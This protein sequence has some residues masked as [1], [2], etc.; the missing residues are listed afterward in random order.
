MTLPE[1]STDQLFLGQALISTSLNPS[2]SHCSSLWCRPPGT[3]RLQPKTEI[4]CC[5]LHRSLSRGEWRRLY[6]STLSCFLIPHS[7]CHRHKSCRS[8]SRFGARRSNCPTADKSKLNSKSLHH[9]RNFSLA[10]FPL[11]SSFLLC[12]SYYSSAL[13]NPLSIFSLFQYLADFF[14][15]TIYPLL[16]LLSEQAFRASPSYEKGIVWMG[17]CILSP[18]WGKTGSAYPLQDI[19]VLDLTG[20]KRK[21]NVAR[22]RWDWRT[23]PMKKLALRVPVIGRQASQGHENLSFDFLPGQSGSQSVA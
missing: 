18:C 20:Q 15:R 9:I 4:Q 1:S 3:C 14:C 17:Q 23:G 21:R 19:F 11:G 2:F 6:F 13:L 22:V 16:C 5:Q 7:P 10:T 12:H 8:I